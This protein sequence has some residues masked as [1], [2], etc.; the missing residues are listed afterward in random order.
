MDL[1][2]MRKL[3][4]SAVVVYCA[5]VVSVRFVVDRHPRKQR[6]LLDKNRV[7]LQQQE[8]AEPLLLDSWRIRESDNVGGAATR[9]IS[10]YSTNHLVHRHRRRLL[11][12]NR[13]KELFQLEEELI[14]TENYRHLS[15]YEQFYRLQNGLDLEVGWNGFY[16]F[17]F[18]HASSSSS[19]T[20]SNRRSSLLGNESHQQSND[21]T[22]HQRRRRL[23]YKFS[24]AF[25]STTTL[26]PATTSTTTT[27]I[28]SGKFD[29][30]QAIP[31]SQGYG[32]HISNVWVGS[33]KPQ[34]KTVIVDTGSHYTAFPCKGCSN[35][36]RSHHTDPYYDPVK[37]ETYH[38][39]QCDEC[40][41]GVVCEKGRCQFSQAY[42]E[43][44]SWDAIQVKDRFYCGGSDV[45]DSVD[46][47]H[48]QYAIDFMFGC[49]TKMS[50]LFLTQLA[51][52]IM[53]M[54]A[55]QAT[56][57]KQLWDKGLIEHNMFAMCFRRELGTS[58]RGVSAGSM[59]MGGVSTNLDTG[60]LVYAKNMARAGWFTVFLKNIFIRVGGGQ[61]AK[62]SYPH[63]KVIRVRINPRTVNSGKGVI[64]DS[65]TTDTYLSKSA[66]PAF[67]K[68]WKEATG[69][70]YSHSSVKLTDEELRN[71][72]TVLVQCHAYVGGKDP[73]IDDYSSIPGYAG[74]L[75]S[76]APED[77]LIAIPATSYMDYSPTTKMYTSRLY[78]TE[79]AGGVLGSNTM[80]GHNVVFDWEHSR[81]GF[82]ESS[83][84]YDKIDV[85]KVAE[86]AG[87]ASDCQVKD[88][89][90]SKPCL[91][92][93]DRPLCRLNQTNIALLGTEKWSAVVKNPGTR[94][95]VTCVAAAQQMKVDDLYRDPVVS[96]DSK[97][98]CEEE[99]PCQLTCPQVD[100]AAK[101]VEV[102]DQ[103]TR[104]NCGDSLWSACDRECFQT[105]V[106]SS[107]FSDGKCH[108]ISRQRRPC[109]I[110]A[111]AR[112]DPC[113]APYSVRI[114]M[115]LRE[116]DIAQWSIHTENAIVESV[117]STLTSLDKKSNVL[118]GD[119]SVR[120]ARSWFLDED[121]PDAASNSNGPPRSTKPY[122]VKAIIDVAVANNRTTGNTSTL[123]DDSDFEEH[124]KILGNFSQQL[125]GQLREVRCY[126][127]DLFVLAKKALSIKTIALKN[128]NFVP[129]LTQ[130]LRENSGNYAL[131][132]S[133]LLNESSVV[134]AWSFR[135]GVDDKVNFFGPRKPWWFGIFRAVHF[136]TVLVT[137]SL[138]VWS[139][140]G[141]IQNVYEN[142]LDCGWFDYHR[143]R[144]W[145][146]QRNR[147][148]FPTMGPEGTTN[149]EDIGTAAEDEGV[150]LVAKGRGSHGHGS[151]SPK[152]RR[153][154]ACRI[155]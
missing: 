71:L 96:C 16:N 73:A 145:P 92:T 103:N 58:K 12:E 146:K 63:R 31:L 106:V 59:T 69:K 94:L 151:T 54:S 38:Q 15:R 70:A 33:P 81:I 72:P 56:L 140:F 110:D 83:C 2:S 104:L 35:C 42:T 99:R 60:P 126:D 22:G 148:S 100:I 85:P 143:L 91:E 40:T 34:R 6:T 11:Q 68:A 109:H 76:S 10:L 82:A 128:S 124:W 18:L 41:G 113:R 86:D 135:N 114:I 14:E 95:G 107:A 119:V 142:G 115:G 25:T 19:S 13:S 127:D 154:G 49:M 78:F 80:Q 4:L 8:E 144:I 89:V 134:A 74:N 129:A 112:E 21:D 43:G 24:N 5:A 36:G 53:G 77:L 62:D 9:R 39:L 152:K 122:G 98:I 137:S 84:S 46:P 1:Q 102:P 79:T 50:G 23:E 141:V 44:S 120:M 111:C 27:K 105:R 130:H 3:A 32:T 20:S 116:V 26:T 97:G 66:A 155:A 65:G 57:P 55:H 133:A 132:S 101:V 121:N 153:G 75:D 125:V 87:Y 118:P 48:H 149:Q 67:N 64:V 61:S 37:S 51:D 117:A 90:L 108:E 150:A 30:Y 29:N 7:P 28:H 52:G 136:I 131:T 47:T 17:S 147:F 88:P 123:E 93:V 138:V 45:L 139:L